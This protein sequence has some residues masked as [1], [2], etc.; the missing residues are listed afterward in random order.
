MSD[1][2]EMCFQLVCQLSQAI[3]AAQWFWFCP[4]PF[5]LPRAE[6]AQA[7]SVLCHSQRY[8]A[9]LL[10][11]TD[12]RLARAFVSSMYRWLRDGLEV[13]TEELAQ[14]YKV[15]KRRG[16]KD[17]P[18]PH[19]DPSKGPADED[20]VQE[21]TS[22]IPVPDSMVTKMYGRWQT[23]QWEVPIAVGGVVP[24]N[25]R[26]NVHCPPLASELPKVERIGLATVS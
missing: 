20:A 26:G 17:A 1:A 3:F 25:D 6:A 15:V 24:K 19:T 4:L 16:V 14:P 10:S 5:L 13:K 11:S 12:D 21:T 23:Q 18:G 2:Q 7:R 8:L 22:V 9:V